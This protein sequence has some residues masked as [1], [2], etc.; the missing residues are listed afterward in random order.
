MLLAYAAFILSC[1]LQNMCKGTSSKPISFFTQN[2]KTRIISHLKLTQTPKQNW[3]NHVQQ[4]KCVPLPNLKS[5]EQPS[6]A[7]WWLQRQLTVRCVVR[8]AEEAWK[9]QHFYRYYA[10]LQFWVKHKKKMLSSLIHKVNH[11]F[12]N[13]L[14]T[15]ESVVKDFNKQFY[16]FWVSKAVKFVRKT[17]HC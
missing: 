8:H 13:T 10:K 4:K 7:E 15:I 17:W 6:N 11:M 5:R 2:K 14:T 1:F 3:G 12:T 9:E 16:P